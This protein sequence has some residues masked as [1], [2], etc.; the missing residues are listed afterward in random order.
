MP[1]AKDSVLA[2]LAGLIAAPGFQAELS[3][4][5]SRVTEALAA[6]PEQPQAWEPLPLRIFHGGLPGGIRSGWVFVLRSGG[7]FGAERHPN[8]HQRT[9]ALQGSAVFELFRNGSWLPHPIQGPGG[10]STV[11]SS[12]SIPAGVWHRIE[13]GS[14]DLVS[15]S[16][17]TVPAEALIEETPVGEDLSVTKKRLYHSPAEH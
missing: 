17:H 9:F 2:R 6:S 15:V 12:V 16:F 14:R 1:E 13:I 10:D 8:S 3:P 5:L 11:G 4:I 7:K